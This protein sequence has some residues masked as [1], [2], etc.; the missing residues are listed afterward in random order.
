MIE[1]QIDRPIP[2]AAGFGG[3]EGVEQ[4][5]RILGGD[6]DAAIRYSR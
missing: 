6:P 1:R 5:V 2:H 3:E 4:T